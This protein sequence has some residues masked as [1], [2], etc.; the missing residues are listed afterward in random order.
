MV[1]MALDWKLAIAVSIHFDS[2]MFDRQVRVGMEQ[3]PAARTAEEGA[4]EAMG[5]GSLQALVGLGHHRGLEEI[6]E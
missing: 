4:A 6:L 5:H 1:P 2:E 3:H